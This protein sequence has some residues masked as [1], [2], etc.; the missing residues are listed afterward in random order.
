[1]GAM[2][3]LPPG[4]VGPDSSS[5]FNPY[6]SENTGGGG[7]A[8]DA[9]NKAANFVTSGRMAILIESHNVFEVP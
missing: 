1:M 4:D 8:V 3:T 2:A 5:Y 7:S 9:L 6:R